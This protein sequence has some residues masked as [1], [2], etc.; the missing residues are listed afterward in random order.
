MKT[1]TNSWPFNV[2]YVNNWAFAENV[3]SKQECK[4]IKNLGKNK[5]ETA[6][7]V[8]GKDGLKVTKKMRESQV[9]FIYPSLETDWL[10]RKMTDL[11]TSVNKDYFKFNLSGLNEGFQ[12]TLYK[13][14]SFYV[15]HLDKNF[16]NKVRK[17]SLTIQLDDP[18]TYEGGDLL[19]HTQ[20]KPEIMDKKQGTCIFFP[21]YILHEVKP[22]TKGKRYSL[23][24]WVTGPNFK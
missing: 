22:V 1:Y 21:S 11:I 2:D 18:K 24:C 19:L 12:L 8:S 5:F 17:L 13:K 7:V 15:K 4:I 20:N 10:Y 9:H 16:N 3:F 6:T 14:N 23:V